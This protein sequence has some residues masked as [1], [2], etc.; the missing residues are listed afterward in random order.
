MM[1]LTKH[2][3]T[4]MFYPSKP[5][6]N[7]F[8]AMNRN[9][10]STLY[11]GILR[12]RILPCFVSARLQS[13]SGDEDVTDTK[14]KCAICFVSPA[15]FYNCS[16]LTVFNATCLLRFPES[17]ILANLSLTGGGYA[18]WKVVTIIIKSEL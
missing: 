4:I 3:N 10:V 11:R 13:S 8:P 6:Y 9:L 2:I 15:H 16:A 12:G 14:R 18:G 7:L 5:K 1:V 17:R